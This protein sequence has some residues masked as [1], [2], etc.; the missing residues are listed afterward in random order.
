MS[1]ILL[2]FS[3]VIFKVQYHAIIVISEPEDE[4]DITWAEIDSELSLP[5]RHSRTSLISDALQLELHSL[6]FLP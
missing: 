2:F 3:I 4:S 5:P 6:D 1:S